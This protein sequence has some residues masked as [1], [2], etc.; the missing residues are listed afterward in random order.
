MGCAALKGAARLAVTGA[1]QVERENAM[2]A[3]KG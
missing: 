2:V 3:S 1:G